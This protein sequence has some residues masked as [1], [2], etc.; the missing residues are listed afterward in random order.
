MRLIAEHETDRLRCRSV[1]WDE[2][3]GFLMIQEREVRWPHSGDLWLTVGVGHIGGER[4]MIEELA[5]FECDSL[6]DTTARGIAMLGMTW[7][8]LTARQSVAVLQMRAWAMR[9]PAWVEHWEP[10]LVWLL[11]ARLFGHPL[12]RVV[13]GLTAIENYYLPDSP[14]PESLMRGH[15]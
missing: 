1:T 3:A 5:L 4:E 15:G 12:T 2:D 11:R 9:A 8:Q 7:D 14:V 6:V 13:A 10:T